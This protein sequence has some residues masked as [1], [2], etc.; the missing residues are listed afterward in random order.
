MPTRPGSRTASDVPYDDTRRWPR[1]HSS[2]CPDGDRFM[3]HAHTS[4]QEKREEE[5]EEDGDDEESAAP[6]GRAAAAA[7]LLDDAPAAADGGNG[8]EEEGSDDD[9]DGDG[10]GWPGAGGNAR[11]GNRRLSEPSI[12]DHEK[13]FTAEP[14]RL[15]RARNTKSRI[16][17]LFLQQ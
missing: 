3:L 6:L 16:R 9:D 15:A 5:E 8:D 17:V 1:A 10:D 11:S 12:A 4:A 2:A 14:I 13:K 7:A